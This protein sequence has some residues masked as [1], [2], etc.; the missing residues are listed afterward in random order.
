VRLR[1][2][3]AGRDFSRDIPVTLPAAEANNES[4]AT[5]WARRKIDDLMGQDW[6]GTQRGTPNPAMRD[7]VTKVGLD[8][9]LMTQFTSFVAV[10]ESVITEGGRPKRVEVP[11]ELP[12]GVSH[13]GIFGEDRQMQMAAAPMRRASSGG[14]SGFGGFLGM[15]AKSAPVAAPPPP[16]NGPQPTVT[17]TDERTG[18]Q[19]TF[20]LNIPPSPEATKRKI[21]ATLFAKKAGEV[22]VKIWLNDQSPEAMQKLKAL[23]VQIVSAPKDGKFVLAKVA[24]EKLMEV[25][26]LTAVRYISAT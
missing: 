8:F 1:G 10:E 18:A 12:H 26:E 13:E 21:D 11:V 24:V 22:D 17:I 19:Q 3:M 16:M 25:A 14:G 6:A 15:R 5:L 7:E 4:I 20:P 9:R 2:K 23:G